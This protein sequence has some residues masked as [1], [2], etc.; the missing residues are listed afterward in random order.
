MAQIHA[1]TKFLNEIAEN[2]VDKGLAKVSPDAI[3]DGAY[4]SLNKIAQERLAPIVGE[5]VAKNNLVTPLENLVFK[6]KRTRDLYEQA[7]LQGYETVRPDST[8]MNSIL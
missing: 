2:L 1:E 8:P 7:L 6:D 4:L 3:D 5:K